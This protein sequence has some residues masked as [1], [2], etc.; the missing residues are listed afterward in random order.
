MGGFCYRDAECKTGSCNTDK[1]C[2]CKQDDDCSGNRFCEKGTLGIG[3]NECVAK[4]ADGVGCTR[5]SQCAGG[6]CNVRCYTPNSKDLGESCNLDGECSR[7][8]CSAA[9]WGVTP[10]KCVCTVNSHCD[11]DEYCNKGVA[12][13]GTNTCK[14]LLPD[15]AVCTKAHMCE[16]GACNVRCYTPNSKSMGQSCNVSAECEKGKCSGTGWGAVPGKCV[17]EENRDC[18]NDEYCNKGVA[19][20]GTNVCKKKLA[21]GKACTKDHQCKSDCCK[22]Y[23]FKLQCRPTNK[24]N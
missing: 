12:G 17:C 16:G 19:G 3:Q 18:D 15:G 14:P 22:L 4:K 6:A 24:C 1:R 9:G 10:G 23:N 20:I 7:G 5:A 11:D 8:Q 21:Q 13:I 2:Q